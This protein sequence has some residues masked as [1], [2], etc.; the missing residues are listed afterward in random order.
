MINGPGV[1]K[2]LKNAEVTVINVRESDFNTLKFTADF[3]E[4]F[5][6]FLHFIDN[7]PKKVFR[8]GAVPQSDIAM[9]ENIPYL[10]PVIDGIVD[11]LLHIFEVHLVVGLK[12]INN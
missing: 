9:L 6:I 11:A 7:V 10:I 4:L 8:Q 12:E 3:L 1:G 5:H 2:G